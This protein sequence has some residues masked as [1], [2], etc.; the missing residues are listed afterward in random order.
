MLLRIDF[1]HCE[2]DEMLLFVTR[3]FNQ[4]ALWT[5]CVYSGQL[6]ENWNYIKAFKTYTVQKFGVIKTPF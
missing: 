5:K 4:F 1:Q 2:T 6:S 3:A